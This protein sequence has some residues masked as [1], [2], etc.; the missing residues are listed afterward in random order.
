MTKKSQPVLTPVLGPW[1][2]IYAQKNTQRV[3]I[4]KEYLETLF[5]QLPRHVL[6]RQNWH[7]RAQNWLPL[8]WRGFEQFTQYSYVINDLSDLD[9]VWDN[10]ASRA[11]TTIRSAQNKHELTISNDISMTDF[12]SHNRQIFERQNIPVPYDLATVERIH[13]ATQ[14]RQASKFFVAKDKEDNIHAIAYIIW[15]EN[16]AH[17]LMNAVNPS[18]MHT[19]GQSLC[20]WEAIKFASSVTQSFDLGGS[21]I[22]PIEKFLRAF[23]GELKSFLGIRKVHN[24]LLKAYYQLRG[25]W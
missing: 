13:Q 24:P 12:Y 1:F 6:Y 4:E 3:T 10:F 25:I 17:Y 2:K 14:Q 7:Y 9:A 23:G 5:A 19:G 18:F 11:R 8:Y 22:A 16:S 21:I 20:L 15:D